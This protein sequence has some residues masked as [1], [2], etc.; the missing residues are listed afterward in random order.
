[1]TQIAHRKLF[2]KLTLRALTLRQSETT[3]AVK[4]S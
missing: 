4:K 3:S 2:E 1:M